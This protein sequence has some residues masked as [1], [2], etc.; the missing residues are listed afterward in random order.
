MIFFSFDGEC[1]ATSWNEKL[2]SAFNRLYIIFGY[3]TART[4]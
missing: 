1:A 3:D 2:I 4:G